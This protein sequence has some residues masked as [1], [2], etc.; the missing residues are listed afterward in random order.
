VQYFTT[1]VSRRNG[2]I[3]MV[4]DAG[5]FAWY[6]LMTTDIASAKA[7]YGKVVGWNSQDAS[8]PDLAYTLFTAGKAP[9]GGLMDLPVQARK[10]GA[11][12]RWVGYVAVDD[13][14]AVARRF[15]RLGGAVYVPPTD[16]NI[17]RISVVADPQ[18]ATLALVKGLKPGPRQTAGLGEAGHVGW[19]ELLADDW[20]KAF[21]FY[22]EL[23]GWQ[24]A[25]HE[26]GSSEKYQL[27]S[28]GGQTL[29]GMFT[30][31]PMEPFPF[32]LYYFNV[33]DVDAAMERVKT[34]G[35]QIFE[36]P[37]ELPDGGW[38]ARCRDPQG[39]AFA[40]QGKRSPDAIRQAPVSDVA[41]STEW[42]GFS[43]RGRL[44][45]TKRGS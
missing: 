23:F 32:W 12:P 43:S 34:G 2:E 38:V 7:F 5:R 1:A 26:I 13:V 14:D 22:G 27:F 37:L 35:G 40:L 11:M 20:K 39:A 8:T 24:K 28:A 19:H 36:G 17:G 6:E 30:K 4:D 41:W 3:D 21:A 16:T 31:R 25:I 44:Q 9:V 33:D 42:G 15:K 18:T 45:V 29:G 10:K